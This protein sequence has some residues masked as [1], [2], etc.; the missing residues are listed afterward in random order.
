MASSMNDYCTMAAT[1]TEGIAWSLMDSAKFV[2][3]TGEGMSAS[4]KPEV[5]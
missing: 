4:V 2:D 1:L 5:K 3:L